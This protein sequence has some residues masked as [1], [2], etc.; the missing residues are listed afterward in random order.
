VHLEPTT[1]LIETANMLKLYL[2]RATKGGPGNSALAVKRLWAT[3]V[4]DRP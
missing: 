4:K 3:L 2:H 1:P